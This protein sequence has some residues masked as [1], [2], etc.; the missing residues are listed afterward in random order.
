MKHGIC[1]SMTYV[2]AIKDGW[3]PL[4]EDLM[5]GTEQTELTWRKQFQQ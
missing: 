2:M 5:A 4:H 3:A 1:I